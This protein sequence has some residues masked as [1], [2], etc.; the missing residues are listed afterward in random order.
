MATG[1]SSLKE[2]IADFS[3]PNAS[4]TQ[5]LLAHWPGLRH[6]HLSGPNSKLLGEGF[7]PH[8]VRYMPQLELL[9]LKQWII[10]L[11]QT[12]LA[13]QLTQ[14]QLDDWDCHMNRLVVVDTSFAQNLGTA[15]SLACIPFA[16]PASTGAWL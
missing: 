16:T 2:L 5:I 14:E 7:V 15:D 13:V 4:D 9:E 6:L 1:L 3:K 12:V 10:H 11:P 8:L